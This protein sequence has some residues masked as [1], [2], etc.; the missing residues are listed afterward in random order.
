MTQ[1]VVGMTEKQQYWIGKCLQERQVPQELAERAAG[2]L[3]VKDASAVLTAL[4]ACPKAQK[5]YEQTKPAQPG[6]YV[7]TAADAEPKVY[8]VVE[9][10]KT[11]RCS[12]K[13]LVRPR[14]SGGKAKWVYAKG[15]VYKL[16]EQEPVTVFE[17][18]AFGHL[19]GWCLCCGTQLT[20]PLSVDAGIGPW[21][22]KKNFGMTQMQFLQQKQGGA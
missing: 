10:K 9:S 7:V 18:A 21:C 13:Q 17:A 2:P 4:F 8:V 6:Y 3:S 12:A 20:V 14:Y 11:G 1:T 15:M 5:Q 22:V 19:H 16:A